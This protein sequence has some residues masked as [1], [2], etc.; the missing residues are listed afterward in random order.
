MPL[1]NQKIERYQDFLITDLSGGW[2]TYDEESKIPDNC[3]TDAQ[4][5]D[6]LGTKSFGPRYGKTLMGSKGTSGGSCRGYT[7]K[8][9]DGSE[10]KVRM[11]DDGTQNILEWYASNKTDW[12]RLSETNFT[13]AKRTAFL[14][15]SDDTEDVMIFCNG[16]ENYSIWTGNH[17]Y[18]TAAVTAGDTDIHVNSTSGFSATGN[19][20]YNGTKIAYTSKTTTKFVVGSAHASAGSD[21]GVAEAT[22]ETT[23][24]ASPKL[25][26]MVISAGRIWGF[27][28]AHPS[29][30][31]YSR[32]GDKSTFSTTKDA[33]NTYYVY[34]D[35][36]FEILP[37]MGKGMTG[38]HA[39]HKSKG[40]VVIFREE[41]IE[42]FELTEIESA[43]AGEY[44]EMP[45]RRTIA[46]G[47]VSGCLSPDGI[48]GIGNEIYYAGTKGGMNKITLDYDNQAEYDVLFSKNV[49][50]TLKD[51]YNDEAA[52]NYK[53]GK[54]LMCC[55]S[56]RSTTNNNRIIVYDTLTGS[57]AGYWVNHNF[58]N[59][60]EYEGEMYGDAS[61]EQ[62]TYKIMDESS[63]GDNLLQVETR[64]RTKRF[65]FGV[66]HRYKS[67]RWAFVDGLVAKATNL[68]V[69]ILY[70]DGGK[71]AKQTR[72]IEGNNSNY[73]VLTTSP[74]F[75][76]YSFGRNPFGTISRPTGGLPVNPFRVWLSLPDD[77]KFFNVAVQF[78]TLNVNA[79]Y[80]I[81]YVGLGVFV[82]AEEK[83][84]PRR[85]I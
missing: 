40:G 61:D 83:R 53:D 54:I 74:A 65:N 26:V 20:I 18:L 68:N 52:L 30:L 4:N 36:G 82:E 15:W 1:S 84:D 79:S 63:F 85:I 3:L 51:Y 17:T 43:T 32:I 76:R 48:V 38:L 67:L 77:I 49:L 73:V 24:S 22:D 69:D 12:E 16:E 21:D 75:G 6:F 78:T 56:T 14:S 28:T 10:V 13:T 19:I 71:L 46:S 34:G 8:K 45:T 47:P 35:G 72:V 27:N 2:A 70:D 57:F 66:P 29:A 64:A 31:Y 7:H 5:L 9:I 25:D 58:T 50:T 60:S 33:Y 37:G 62:T 59:L 42:L 41:G 44:I 11:R 81:S 55:K 39:A 23:Y 80:R